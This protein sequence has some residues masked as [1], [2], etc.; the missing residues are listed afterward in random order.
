MRSISKSVLLTGVIAFV[1][2]VSSFAGNLFWIGGTGNWSDVAHWSSSSGGASCACV[3]GPTDNV[4]FDALSFGSNGQVVTVDVTPSTCNNMDWTGINKTS[5]QL[6]GGFELHIYGSLTFKSTMLTTNYTGQVYFEGTNL[7]NTITSAGKVFNNVVYFNGAGGDWTLQD[8]FVTLG[9]IYLNYGTL[10]ANNKNITAS[11]FYSNNSNVRGLTLGSSTVTMTTNCSCGWSTGGS[12]FAF[13]AGTSLIKYTQA[14]AYYL[15][16]TAGVNEVFYDV[17][18][19]NSSIASATV[20][21]GLAYH[22]VTFSGA[23]GTIAANSGTSFHD[24]TFGGDGTMSGNGIYDDV[25]F[26]AGKTYILES[27]KTQTINNSITVTGTC[28]QPIILHSN[29]TGTQAT[30]SQGTGSVTATY[31]QIQDIAATGGATFTANISSDIQNNSGWNFTSMPTDLYWIGGPGNWNSP[32]HWSLTSNGATACLIPTPFTNAHFD[33][34]SFSVNG[35]IVTI[36]VPAYCK[37]MDWST[38]NETSIQMSGTQDLHI[39]GSLTMQS[40]MILSNYTGPIYFESSAVGKTITSSGRTFSS[41]IY[42]NGNGGDWTLQ[43][44]FITTG[45]ITLNYGTW[46]SNS[47]NITCNTFNSNNSNMRGLTLGSSMFTQTTNCSCGWNTG[48]GNFSFDAGTSLIKYTQAA[49]YNLYLTAGANDAF[50]DVLFQNNTAAS[51]NITGGLS[52]H[53]VTFSSAPSTISAGSATSFH[54]AV[55]NGDGN[56]N[57]S[58]NYDDLTFTL[59]KTYALE[60][61]KTQIINN[62]LTAAGTCSQP[63]MIHSSNVGYQATLSRATGTVTIS[64]VEMQDIN[65]T[66][67]ATFIANSSTNLLNN[68]GWNFTTSAADLYWIGGSGNWNA[69]AHWSTSSGG[70]AACIIPGPGT[71]AHFDALS[72]S[73]SA[74]IVTINVPAYCKNMDWSA[75][76][77]ASIQMNGASDLHIFGSLTMKSTMITTNY[78]GV[79]YFESTGAGK[80]ITSAGKTFSNAVYFSGSGGDWTLQDAFTTLGD[81]TL[82]FGTLYTNNK[83]LTCNTFSS[84]NSNTRG[85]TLGSSIVTQTTNC[86]CG[87]NTGGSNFAFDAGTSLIVYTQTAGY[88][89]YLTAGVND[90]FYDV[91][92]QSN[93]AAYGYLSGGLAYHNVTFNASTTLAA[94]NGTSFHN[95][96]FNNDGAINN[97]N[98][99]DSLGFAAGHLYTLAQST[100][101]T[102]NN[103]FK[104]DGLCGLPVSMISNSAGLQ[105]TISKA[106]GSVTTN[107]T[108]LKDMKAIG[109]AT[110]TANNAT[111][112]GNNSGWVINLSTPVVS[113]YS[114]LQGGLT[115]TFTNTSTGATSYKWNFGD[116][117]TSTLQNPVHTY[118]FGGNY[119]ACLIAYNSCGNSDTVCHNVNPGCVPPVA[120]FN[121][122]SSGLTSTFTNTSTNAATVLWNFGDASTSTVLNPSHTYFNAGTYTVCLTVNNGCGNNSVC[123]TVTVTCT[124]P[125]ASYYYVVNGMTVTFSNIS[126]NAAT[127]NWNFG[128]TYTSTATSPVHTYNLAGV[129]NVSLKTT[130]GCGAD[131][132]TQAVTIVCAAPVANFITNPQGLSVDFVSTSSNATSVSWNFG[133]GSPVSILPSVNHSYSATGTYSV[134]LTASNGCG[135]NQY[136]MNVS[137][138]AAPAAGYSVTASAFNA[139]FTNT[140]TNG[141]N[142]YWTFGDS[143]ASN[144]VSPAHTYSLSGTY[145]VCLTASNACGSSTTCNPLKIVC[146]TFSSQPICE[147]TVDNTSTKNVIVW[148]KPVTTSIDS[149]RIYRYINS[150]YKYIGG[151]NYPD[152]SKFI[153]V[154]NGVDPNVQ[155]YKYKITL[156]DTCGNESAFSTFHQTIHL[157]ASLALPPNSFNLAWNDYLGF[158]V[159]QY[160]VMIDSLNNGNWY[161]RD[162]VSFGSPLTWTDSHHYSS[163]VNYRID[164][165]HPTGC[166]ITIVKDPV[167]MASN[168]NLSKSNINRILDTNAVHVPFIDN[169]LQLTIYPNPNNG[170]FY[171]NTG[172]IKCTQIRVLDVLGREILKINEPVEN[173]GIVALNIS[174]AKGVYVLKVY[175][176][177]GVANKKFVVE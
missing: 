82:N 132:V 44:D 164:V 11:A 85:L 84:N 123:K 63:I 46:Y 68:T 95:V 81:I 162:S 152:S 58:A 131:S 29:T 1:L 39:Y 143:Y 49:A 103:Y 113:A 5:I 23:P 168:L 127:S 92:F 106:G 38:V 62:S 170:S 111:N 134:C 74:Q 60:Y 116:G 36:N 28:A 163:Q 129:Y 47:K 32:S 88:G 40:S 93:T 118:N 54:S 146:T 61:G 70:P 153:D 42:F 91:L 159:T 104:A 135:T 72:F 53:D 124:A 114:S 108:N 76:N 6:S 102:I 45:D 57:G 156:R 25:I 115:T 27:N 172:K 120:N 65:A 48:G 7:G 19:Q 105:A 66:G 140:S 160:Y 83:N 128:D 17:Q 89:L 80:T 119:S 158:N 79:L 126:T 165:A 33:I 136:C 3:P 109:G 73:T 64:Y 55:F 100:T 22:N 155:S 90:V 26:A 8:A 161:K 59:G 43:D 101:Q 148:E 13:D 56:L 107:Y 175:S 157:Q 41:P 112:S 12:N 24:V 50:Y 174:R 110:F 30:I 18:F 141:I 10:Y 77:K 133:D 75:I 154:T 151:V 9:D 130:N 144:S 177:T 67:G 20:S 122:S 99:F 138:C 2:S 35:Q 117:N 37:N 139:N 78:T 71:N 14:A 86:S 31:V 87:W 21:G 4:F 145:T 121:S 125:L 169:E 176:S 15:Y 96:A 97:N 150:A 149:F 142:Y 166:A 171:I 69:P 16:L 147:I 173:N 94:N 34:N 52:F 51:N 167:L 137:V 98:V